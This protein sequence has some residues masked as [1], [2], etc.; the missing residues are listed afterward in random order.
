MFFES[1]G[2]DLGG[3]TEKDIN[4]TAENGGLLPAGVYKCRL[5]CVKDTESKSSG[6]MGKELHFTI[7]EG[8]CA[9]REIKETIWVSDKDTA[10]KRVILFAARLGLIKPNAKGTYDPIEGK[11][12]FSDCYGAVVWLEVTHEA[13]K[14]EKT[15]KEGLVARVP[16]GGIWRLDD[17]PKGKPVS[18]GTHATTAKPAPK[19]APA[20]KK[21]VDLSDI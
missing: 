16:F 9:E 6:T 20:P 7:V 12:D 3:Y 4:D 10:K 18:K 5:D 2:I 13:Y 8:P 1:L 11:S 17:P 15:G 14:N 21:A 19:P